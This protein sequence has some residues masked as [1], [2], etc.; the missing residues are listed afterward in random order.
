ME[1]RATPILQYSFLCRELKRHPEAGAVVS[2]NDI[3]F[4]FGQ[5]QGKR[6][7]IILVNCWT[8]CAG[9]F[10]ERSELTDEDGRVVASTSIHKFTL[11]EAM[12][13]YLR[14]DRLI[15]DVP[16]PGV[17]WLV[18]FLGDVAAMRYPV[19]IRLPQEEEPPPPQ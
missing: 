6:L 11:A 7:G 19:R 18:V 8:G 10:F 16:R 15:F 12:S 5:V 14:A 13:R 2:A 17:Y 3:V 9:T 1:E 4:D